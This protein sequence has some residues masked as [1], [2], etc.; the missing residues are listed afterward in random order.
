MAPGLTCALTFLS[1]ALGCIKDH[2]LQPDRRVTSVRLINDLLEFVVGH[3][4]QPIHRCHAVR[5]P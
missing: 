4:V 5:L 1:S 3:D 2:L